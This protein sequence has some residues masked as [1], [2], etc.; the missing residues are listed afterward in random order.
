MVNAVNTK[1]AWGLLVTW[2]LLSAI[3]M[4]QAFHDDF[5]DFLAGT[6]EE[7][8]QAPGGLS[9]NGAVTFLHFVDEA[10]PCSRFSL[11]HI[12][13]IERKYTSV[14]HVRV[15]GDQNKVSNDLSKA[16]DW[17]VASPSIA[18][19]NEQGQ[20]S[21]YGPYSNAAICGEGESLVDAVMASLAEDSEFQWMNLLAY[22]CFCDWPESS[23]STKT[24]R[25]FLAI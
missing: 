18:I 19:I 21:Y 2:A 24:T 25:G 5:R 8:W 9:S 1:L 3:F 6:A 13:E 16:Y 22:G 20:L 14:K 12:E 10:C 15:Y 7:T 23:W 17:V 11:P 4:W